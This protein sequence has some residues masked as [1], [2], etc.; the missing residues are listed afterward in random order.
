MLTTVFLCFLAI[1]VFLGVEVVY[2]L[3]KK[4]QVTLRYLQKGPWQKNCNKI[5]GFQ[6]K[7]VLTFFVY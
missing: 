1:L 7:N 6:E 3:K 4:L 5:K 2:N